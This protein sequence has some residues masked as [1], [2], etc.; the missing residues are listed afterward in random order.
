MDKQDWEDHY[1]AVGE[2]EGYKSIYIPDDKEAL[3]K[4]DKIRKDM[5]L[6]AEKTIAANFKKSRAARKR[7]YVK[8]LIVRAK[9]NKA[10]RDACKKKVG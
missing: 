5:K 10:F 7:H 2:V 1:E 4:R 6:D 8:M 9:T 3:E